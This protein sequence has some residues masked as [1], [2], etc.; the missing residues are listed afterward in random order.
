MGQVKLAVDYTHLG[1]DDAELFAAIMADEL[2]Q[3]LP[4][5]RPLLIP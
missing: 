1:P 4:A 5:L 3:Q 2:S